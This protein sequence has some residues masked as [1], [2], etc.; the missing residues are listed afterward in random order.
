MQGI[1]INI[2]QKENAIVNEEGDNQNIPIR[3]NIFTKRKVKR[4]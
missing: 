2:N 3:E 4:R 1:Q